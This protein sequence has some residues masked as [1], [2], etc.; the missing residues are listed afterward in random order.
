MIT[1]LIFDFDGLIIDSETPEFAV[2][3]QT[4]AAHGRELDFAIWADWI[5]RPY[6]HFDVYSYFRDHVNPAVDIDE[7]RSSIRA[8]VVS[9]TLEQPLLPGVQNY[10]ADAGKAGLSI[11][12]AS[13][14]SR[15]H[16]C[17]HLERLGLLHH[18]KAVKCFEDTAAHK[19][20]PAPYL[21]ALEQLGVSPHE[22]VAF[23]DSPNGVTSAKAAGIFCV[24]VPNNLTRRLSL[25]HAD[26]RLESLADESLQDILSRAQRRKA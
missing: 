2:W 8:R 5:G 19:P 26:H 10:L 14:S 15:S 4:F 13:S 25:D 16:V 6:T 7:L 3:Q 24:A 20:D 22:A 18:F 12:V 1:A 23:E 17:G 21:A 9:L 11:A